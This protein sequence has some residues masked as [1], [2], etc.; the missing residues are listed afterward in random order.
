MNHHQGNKAVRLLEMA[1]GRDLLPA[2]LESNSQGG[3]NDAHLV[4]NRMRDAK[5]KQRKTP[6]GTSETASHKEKLGI[7]PTVGVD[8]IVPR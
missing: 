7:Q 6:T 4:R 5:Q 3:N 1:K 2:T 8:Y